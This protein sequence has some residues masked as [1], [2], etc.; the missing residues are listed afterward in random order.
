MIESRG[1][2]AVNQA[3]AAAEAADGTLMDRLQMLVEMALELQQ[4]PETPADLGHA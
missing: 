3:L 4:A 1:A 2:H